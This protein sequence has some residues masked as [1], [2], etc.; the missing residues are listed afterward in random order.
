MS[1]ADVRAAEILHDLREAGATAQIPRQLL[2]DLQVRGI[3]YAFEQG[4]GR[5]DQDPAGLHHRLRRRVGAV[6]AGRLRTGGSVL[7]FGVPFL[8]LNESVK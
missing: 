2:A 7:Q 3:R 8:S 6:A 4:V 5:P 1:E